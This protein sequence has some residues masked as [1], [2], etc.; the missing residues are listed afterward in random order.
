M[1]VRPRQRCAVET[2]VAPAR[3]VDARL[4]HLWHP[5][6]GRTCPKLHAHV[7]I[8]PTPNT[9]LAYRYLRAR[10]NPEA[11]RALVRGARLAL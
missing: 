1:T 3:W 5:P 4:L 2:L 7:P 9:E 10:S 6:A 8:A 11:M